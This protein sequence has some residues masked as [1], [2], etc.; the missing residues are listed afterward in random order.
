VALGAHN[1]R[2]PVAPVIPET[3]DE[4][5]R[6][7]AALVRREYRLSQKKVEKP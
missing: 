3:E 5:R 2:V 1:E 7:N 6:Y 4:K